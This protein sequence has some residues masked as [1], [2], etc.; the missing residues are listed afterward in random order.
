MKEGVS[1][2]LLAAGESRRMGRTDKLSLLIEGEPLIARAARTL[3]ET[4]FN[5]IVVVV[6]GGSTMARRLMGDLSVEIVENSHFREGQMT[7][8]RCGI[9]A[10]RKPYSGVVVSLADQ[11]LLCSL[12]F[13]VLVEAFHSRGAS[14]IV[15]PVHEG[16]RGNPVVVPYAHCRQIVDSELNIGCRHIIE[17][18]PNIVAAVRMDN[19]HTVFDLDTPPDY[20]RLLSRLVR[21]S[22]VTVT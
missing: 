14:S 12:D 20:R 4:G 15:V 2:I 8:V 5:E 22:E 21:R 1:A 16:R 10:L 17:D 13:H 11:P 18:N 7:S 6:G 9:K 3:L 19:D